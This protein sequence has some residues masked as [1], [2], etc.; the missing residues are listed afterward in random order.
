MSEKSVFKSLWFSVVMSILSV[1][2]L[3][4][5][6]RFVLTTDDS[7]RRIIVLG[8]WAVIAIGWIITL[9]VRLKARKRQ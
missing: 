5:Y 9:V 3:A 8:L 7:L 6:T 1:L 4:E 2:M